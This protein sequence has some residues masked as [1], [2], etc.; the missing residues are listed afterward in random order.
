MD[1]DKIHKQDKVSED[2]NEAISE[3]SA[4]NPDIEDADIKDD[5]KSSEEDAQPISVEEKYQELEDRFLRLAAEYD[6]YRRRTRKE[7]EALYSDSITDV[8][9]KFLPVLDNVDRALET[10][11]KCENSETIAFAEG[12][13][14]I[15]K[16]I[17]E[18]F[19]S[20]DIEEIAALGETFDPNLH[21]AVSHIDD[22]DKDPQEITEVFQIGFIRK[23]RVLRH[24]VVQVAN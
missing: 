2:Q 8:V 13:Q 23:D 5:Q 1:K 18:V 9:C 6:N 7:K 10:A 22:E 19:A 20:L 3:E 16:Q 17:E 12:V 14:L 4:E 21:H 11:D 24:S 15:R